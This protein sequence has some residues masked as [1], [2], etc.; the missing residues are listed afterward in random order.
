[1][2]IV[3]QI[4]SPRWT[5]PVD[6]MNSVLYEHSVVVDHG[7]I[8]A[9][10]S[11]SEIDKHYQSENT[12]ELE[13]HILI[14]G[15]VNTHTHAA[16]TL[17]RGFL[18]DLAMAAWLAEIWKTESRWVDDN[19]VQAGTDLA[20]AEMVRSGSTCFNDMYFFPDIVAERAVQ[21]GIRAC[22]G[23]IVIDFP[24]VWAK[25]TDEYIKKG[26]VVRD[27]FQ[28]SSLIAT[29]LAPHAPY[30]ISDASFHKISSLAGEI[31][32][33]VHIHLHETVNEVQESI[34]EFGVRPI[35]RLQ[36]FGLLNKNLMAVHMTDLLP[37]EINT[38]SDHGVHVIH[39]PESNLKL[40]SGICP[41]HELQKQGI[42]VAIGTDG[43]ASNNDLDMIGEMRTASLLAKGI[44]R[45][46][47]AMD[48]YTSL[49][50]ATI[51][52]AKALGL[53]DKIGSI[54]AG[55]YADLTAIDLSKPAT[56]PIYNPVSQLVYSA[57]RDQVSDVWVMGKQVLQNGELTTIDEERVIAVANEW[58]NKIS[59]KR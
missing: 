23:M 42:N 12:T 33:R 49:R 4:I 29:C 9:V 46:P 15:L 35:E 44:S 32:C 37:A 38:I 58:R 26:L 2:K 24:T 34:K 21:A 53:D 56:Q 55:K 20:C 54:E 5:I 25:N 48:A 10:N 39:C 11:V 50:T 6:N 51:N 36:Q 3:D 52:G 40:A 18:D 13:N 59:N 8:I 14:P 22:I 1:M 17:L 16:M 47:Q 31:D 41:V 57:T 30:S 28:H 19:F 7:K 27:H 45:S 43:T